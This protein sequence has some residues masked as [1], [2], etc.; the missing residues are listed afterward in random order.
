MRV[1]QQFACLIHKIA[2]TFTCEKLKSLNLWLRVSIHGAECYGSS[3]M[4]GLHAAP[5]WLN[6]RESTGEQN[7]DRLLLVEPGPAL[8]PLLRQV[9]GGVAMIYCRFQTLSSDLIRR[10]APDCILSPLYC[11]RFDIVDLV[12]ELN[13]CRYTGALVAVSPPLPD[14]SIVLDELKDLTQ[15]MQMNLLELT[16]GRGVRRLHG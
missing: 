12:Q 2:N 6:R 16:E 1:A 8:G 5:V 3:L 4:T 9:P 11:P 13:A 7:A 15:R 10:V 14:A